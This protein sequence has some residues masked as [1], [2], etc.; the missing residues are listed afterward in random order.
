[1]YYLG[2]LTFSNK[3]DKDNYYFVISN[4]KARTEFIE[5]IKEQ[6]GL[7][8]HNLLNRIKNSLKSL[9]N[10]KDP[11]NFISLFAEEILNNFKIGIK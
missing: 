5:K 11:S 2:A 4:N 3:T 6:L 7:D 1:M 10:D 9:W 8:K